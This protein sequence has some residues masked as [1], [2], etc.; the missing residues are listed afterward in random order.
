MGMAQRIQG[1]NEIS[2]SRRA[3]E[4]L[5]MEIIIA[6]CG[7]T[8]PHPNQLFAPERLCFSDDSALLPAVSL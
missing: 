7:M 3:V 8:F 4:R 1:V 6:D 2:S 5:K